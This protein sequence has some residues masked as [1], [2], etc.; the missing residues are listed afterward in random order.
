MDNL[1]AEAWRFLDSSRRPPDIHRVMNGAPTSLSVCVREHVA[2]V[3]IAGRANFTIS[4]DFKKLLQ[5]LQGD[6]VHEIILDLTECS[7]MDSTFLGVVASAGMKC[8]AAR[9]AG[10]HGI[11]KLYRPNERVQELLDNLDVLNLF[12][13]LQEA[14]KMGCFEQVDEGETTKVEL[15][16]TCLEAHQTLMNTSPENERRFKDATEFFEKNLRDEE[17]KK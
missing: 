9:M 2:C 13:L 7:I 14:P 12:T 3:R 17:R 4:P 10:G 6:G 1:W 5:Q 11:I 16:R 15:N 8:D